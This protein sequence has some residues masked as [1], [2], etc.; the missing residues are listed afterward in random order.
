V[1][2]KNVVYLL[3]EPASDLDGFIETS[4]I[5]ILRSLA[6]EKRMVSLTMHRARSDGSR[7]SATPYF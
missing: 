4:V 7:I 2:E 5:D 3:N 1:E 6:V